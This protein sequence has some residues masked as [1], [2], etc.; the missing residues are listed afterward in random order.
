MAGNT[1]RSGK[2]TPDYHKAS[3]DLLKDGLQRS[4]TERFHMMTTLM[5]MNIMFQQAD[6]K[7]Q[8]LPSEKK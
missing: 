7:H 1:N 6:I 2:L 5:K 3:L 8:T 4:Y